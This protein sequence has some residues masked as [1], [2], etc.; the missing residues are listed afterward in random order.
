MPAMPPTDDQQPPRRGRV[1]VAGRDLELLQLGTAH[2]DVVVGHLL[3]HL[4]VR[5]A[6][7]NGPE[8]AL[9]QV[10]ARQ[11]GAGKAEGLDLGAARARGQ[12]DVGHAFVVDVPADRRHTVVTAQEGVLAHQRHL[13]L[14]L[15]D[16]GE[17]LHVEPLAEAA[18]GAQV[19]GSLHD[20]SALSRA[21]ERVRASAA[22]RCSTW[23]PR[24][25]AAVALCTARLTSSGPR[26]RR[27]R[28]ARR[29]RCPR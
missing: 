3:A 1:R 14:A 16:L 28:T 19:G 22:A 10:G 18:A 25:A 24:S 29:S 27:R 4:V 12:H 20:A 15:R 6:F 26:R 21:R 9:A 23:M 17:P 11:R 2:A 7:G 13:A 8:H 5:L